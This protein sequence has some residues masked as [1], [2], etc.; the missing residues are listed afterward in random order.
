MLMYADDIIIISKSSDELQELF[1]VVNEYSA[2]FYI[3]FSAYKN[4]VMVITGGRRERE[5]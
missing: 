5:E 2:Q 4:Q 1:A 3:K